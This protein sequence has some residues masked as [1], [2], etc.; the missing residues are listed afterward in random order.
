MSTA[1]T[2]IQDA[3]S[4]GLNRLSPGETL[5]A[6]TASLA[7]SALNSVVDAINGG[8]SLLWRETLE[9]ATVT[10][11][12]TLGTTWPGI[13]SGAQILGCTYNEGDGDQYVAPITMQ[14]WAERITIK[15]TGGVPQVFA[16][17]GAATVYFYPAPV[18]IPITLRYK[19]AASEF[20]AL[21]T[22][23][24]LPA[25]WRSGLADML[26]EKLATVLLGGVPAK[27]AQNAAAAKLRLVGQ[28]MTPGIV[29]G[30]SGSGNILNGF[31]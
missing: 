5:D 11:T 2:I 13:A 12:G 27:V 20:A 8:K 18:A 25:G 26:A 6:D 28:S 24:V 23:Y 17:D 9:T 14:Q 3:L 30:G 7:L 15:S 21:D 16:H 31:E 1:R 22:D 29:N 4:F 19:Q 10:G